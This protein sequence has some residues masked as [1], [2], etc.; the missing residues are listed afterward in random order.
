MIFSHWLNVAIRR[1]HSA[2]SVKSSN[3]GHSPPVTTNLSWILISHHTASVGG[4]QTVSREFS[5]G[6]P[7]KI[8]GKRGR[9]SNQVKST[10]S[11][12]F[13]LSYWSLPLFCWVKDFILLWQNNMKHLLSQDSASKCYTDSINNFLDFYSWTI[14][15][16]WLQRVV[17]STETFSASMWRLFSCVWLFVM[18]WTIQSMEFSGWEHWSG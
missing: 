1:P 13:G 7:G 3:S 14:H 4:K 8:T 6:G 11:P 2:S 10:L 15:L 18:P 17:S 12:S 9:P 16:H 5:A